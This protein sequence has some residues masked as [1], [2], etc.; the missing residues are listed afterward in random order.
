MGQ[1][2]GRVPQF[3][4]P[5]LTIYQSESSRYQKGEESYDL[6]AQEPSRMRNALVRVSRKA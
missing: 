4:T 6:T 5:E 3:S 2:V 1:N